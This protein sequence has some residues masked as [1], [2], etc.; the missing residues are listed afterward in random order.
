MSSKF[1]RDL[2]FKLASVQ[3]KLAVVASSGDVLSDLNDLKE[4]RKFETELAA[5]ISE[6][7][8]AG[9]VPPKPLAFVEAEIASL[10]A[11][12]KEVQRL[13]DSGDDLLSPKQLIENNQK[14]GLEKMRSLRS[15]IERFQSEL[16]PRAAEIRSKIPRQCFE[17]QLVD[18]RILGIWQLKLA[19]D[20]QTEEIPDLPNLIQWVGET[21]K[22]QFKVSELNEKLSA[23]L[24]LIEKLS[25]EARAQLAEL[26][27]T[28][29]KLESGFLN[30]AK[31]WQK[32][33]TDKNRFYDSQ[34]VKWATLES[35]IN[36][37]EGTLNEIRARSG[38]A[39]I[40]NA[41]N[42]IKLDDDW[43]K[44]EPD[45]ELGTALNS[46]K[47]TAEGYRFKIRIS[48][49]VIALVFCYAA[50]E[51][52]EWK[53]NARLAQVAAA[54]KA[55]AER[56]AYLKS[57]NA[58]LLRANISQDKIERL[59]K[60][61]GTVVAW[62]NDSFGQS[63]IPQALSGVVAIAA[64]DVHSLALKSDG[65]VVAWGSNRYGESAI[66]QGLS[67]VVAIAGGRNHSLA[68]KSDGTVV[69]WGNNSYGQSAIPQALSGVVAIATGD[70]HSLA[71]KSD[72]TVVAW[73]HDS[74]ARSTI[75]QGLS[76]V[77]AIAAGDVHNLALKSDGTVVAWGSNFYGQSA[78]PQALSGVVAIAVGDDHNLAL[79]SDG[80]VVAWGNNSYG[81]SAIPQALSGAVAVATGD[82]HSLALKSDG[83]VVA[84]GDNSYG[85]SAIPQG[86]SGVVAIAGGASHS[87]ALKLEPDN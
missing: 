24:D 36:K 54:A 72:G 62:G 43:K 29:V 25:A 87:L 78:I 10:L 4:V 71:L 76:G 37:F 16:F 12:G 66:P 48:L 6:N 53:E 69:A 73:G 57:L 28:I 21:G 60:M 39:K 64:G 18:Q 41:V 81:Q 8:K 55:E 80:T 3:A 34:D 30:E 63:A 5:L 44:I 67:G 1:D 47:K 59:L 32:G 20:D 74:F 42:Q 49:F 38:N 14:A 11:W 68:L 2:I 51:L 9:A 58:S 65:T 84:W 77:V 86:L 46:I 15:R 79:K 70:D 7:S 50:K 31:K 27:S 52:A 19:A 85:Q 40:I 83:P 45:S 13:I 82:D 33:R 22:T 75:P 26:E 17:Q 23:H 56:P 61:G 35:K